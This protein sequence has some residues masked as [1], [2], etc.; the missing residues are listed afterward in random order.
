M[1]FIKLELIAS[2][3][4]IDAK[5]NF[6]GVLATVDAQICQNIGSFIIPTGHATAPLVPNLLIEAKPPKG[7]VDVAKRQA[8]YN[9]ALGA[10]QSSCVGILLMVHLVRHLISLQ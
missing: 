4:T 6:Y 10:R 3:T 9:G 2:K 7:G 1:V 8:C 5:L